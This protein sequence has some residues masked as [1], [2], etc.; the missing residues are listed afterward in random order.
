MDNFIFQNPTKI[1]FGKGTENEVGKEVSKYS[2]KIL[3]HYGG[4]SIKKTGLYERVTTSLKG[5]GVEYLELSGVKPNPRLNLVREGIRI[6]RENNV[7]FILAVGG[8]SVIDSSKA[9]A[10]GTVYEGDVWDFYTGKALP[11]AA[12]PLG[13]VL[14]IPAAGS[15][16]SSS[17][18]ITNEEGWYKR[19]VG[20]DLIYPRFS[21]L[22]PELTYT[23]PKYQVACG[24]ADILAHLMERYF[25][26]TK[27]V[28][29][30]DRLIEST[31]KTIINNVPLVIKDSDNYD[32][33]AQVMW[34]GT[35]A[36]NNILST[37]RVGDWGSHD[38]EHELSGIY[39]VAHGAGLAVVFPAW[40]KY[41]YKYDLD[42][43]IQFAVRVWNTEQDYFN[44]EETA[45]KGIKKLEEFFKSIGLPITLE[46]L[47]IKDDRLEEMADKATDS[48]QSTLGNFVKLTK[49]DV[50]NIL[51]L[52]RE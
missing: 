52:A 26:N 2:K 51:K 36:H 37:G 10:M 23:L 18:V 6:C 4:G 33:W 8:G 38:I 22:N 13:T 42:R 1:I 32:A 43:F 5:V 47:G 40:M 39:D 9:I 25:T 20:S 34:A 21:I 44:P 30:I 7:D 49:K 29:L 46:G 50:Y 35:I 48:D 41:V 12:L 45:L 19:G 16:S 3:L 28:E 24:A 11:K 15:E 17:S 14:T 31:M 27:S